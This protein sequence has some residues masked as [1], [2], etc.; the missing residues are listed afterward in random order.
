MSGAVFDTARFDRTLAQPAMP[1]ASPAPVL[2]WLVTVVS[3]GGIL[4]TNSLSTIGWPCCG[5]ED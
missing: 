3:V 2:L 5:R 4:L 1:A